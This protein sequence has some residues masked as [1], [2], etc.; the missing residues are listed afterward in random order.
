MGNDWQP[1]QNTLKTIYQDFGLSIH[2]ELDAAYLKQAF[3]KT[4]ALWISN[5]TGWTTPT[6]SLPSKTRS[7]IQGLAFFIPIRLIDSYGYR[8]I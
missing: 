7:P 6:L 5:L 1:I 4:E 2:F 3:E 8:L